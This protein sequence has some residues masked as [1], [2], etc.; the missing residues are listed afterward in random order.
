M[1]VER[2]DELSALYAE[3]VA[4]IVHV[5]SGRWPDADEA[6]RLSVRQREESGS[7]IRSW[8][9]NSMRLVG[10]EDR[11]GQGAIDVLEPCLEAR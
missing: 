7:R 6:G 5:N 9:G 3:A 11:R 2:N 4:N 10:A 8:K 1:K